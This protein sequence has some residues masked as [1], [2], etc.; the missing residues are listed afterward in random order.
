M[1]VGKREIKEIHKVT[2]VLR[3]VYLL[4]SRKFFPV[5]K[6]NTQTYR[7]GKNGFR[8]V[9]VLHSSKF[10]LYWRVALTAI[11]NN[12]ET[13]RVYKHNPRCDIKKTWP[14]L[15]RKLDI[16]LAYITYSARSLSV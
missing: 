7:G 9:C 15:T 16:S 10:K 6:F 14:S 12:R 5:R 1:D 11:E 4:Y 8:Y 13:N 2:Y 3:S